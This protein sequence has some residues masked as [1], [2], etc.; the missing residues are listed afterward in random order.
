M[1][2]K[3]LIEWRYKLGLSQQDMAK[4]LAIS[5]GAYSLK[6]SGKRGFNQKEMSTI[7][8]KLKRIEP[9]LNM[10]DIFLI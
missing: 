5:A 8:N 3:K 9:N 4:V 6:E 2:Q 1:K 7:F 10:Q